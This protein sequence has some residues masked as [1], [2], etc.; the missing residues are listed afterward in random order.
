MC[1]CLSRVS[2]MYEILSLQSNED[3]IQFLCRSNS[4]RKEFQNWA[5][6]F[7]LISYQQ[8]CH[9]QEK[10]ARLNHAKN[11]DKKS[12]NVQ[13]DDGEGDEKECG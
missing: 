9:L 11:Y 6:L 12:K 2:K 5:A 7:L 4:E 1:K 8:N 13:L 10:T 3:D